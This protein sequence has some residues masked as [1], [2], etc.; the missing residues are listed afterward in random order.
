MSDTP[1][2]P[3]E[4]TNSTEI[5]KFTPTPAMLVWLD[6]AMRTESDSI[7]DI[8]ENCEPKID[9]TNWYKWLGQEGFIEWF[10]TT[11]NERLKGHAWKLDMIGLKNSKR[12]FNYW[13]SMQQRVGNLQE[14]QSQVSGVNVSGNAIIFTN[15]KNGTESK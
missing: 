14:K 15:F 12:D 5:V 9:R 2:L 7:S 6:A 11:W 8:A 13:K 10:N 4:S 1:T 3:V